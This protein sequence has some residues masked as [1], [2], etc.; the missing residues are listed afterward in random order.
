MEASARCPRCGAAMHPMQGGGLY[1]LKCDSCGYQ[2]EVEAPAQPAAPA[3]PP[4]QQVIQIDGPGG[5]HITANLGGMGADYMNWASQ[6][7]Q[8]GVDMPQYMHE[9]TPERKQAAIE[10]ARAFMGDGMA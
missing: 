1:F 10:Q 7:G 4:Q 2:T 9:L 5:V 8:H 6:M 3:T